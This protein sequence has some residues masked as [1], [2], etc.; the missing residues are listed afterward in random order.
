M[1]D[2][3]AVLRLTDDDIDKLKKW[4]KDICGM[5][6]E[7]ARFWGFLGKDPGYGSNHRVLG[8]FFNLKDSTDQAK[9]EYFLKVYMHQAAGDRADSEN[10]YWRLAFLVGLLGL[11]LVLG[12][13]FLERVHAEEWDSLSWLTFYLFF[14]VV[15]A[16]V[17]FFNFGNKIVACLKGLK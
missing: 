2:E 12:V 4:Y 13:D 17:S 11:A 8:R 9:L 6:N 16:A 7:E 1:S 15:I 14:A 5:G 3:E 10:W